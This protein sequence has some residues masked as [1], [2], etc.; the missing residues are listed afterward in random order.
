MRSSGTR[1]GGDYGAFEV[2]EMGKNEICIVYYSYYAKLG[3]G[4]GRNTN[5]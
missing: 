3:K 4:I 2:L 1:T 5:P